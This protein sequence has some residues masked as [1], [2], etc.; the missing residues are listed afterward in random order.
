MEQ[1]VKFAA[2]L[3][4][5]VARAKFAAENPE[6]EKKLQVWQSLSPEDRAK[7]LHLDTGFL[8]EERSK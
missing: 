2:D 1:H 8:P 6:L 4:L 5:L 7:L 3:G